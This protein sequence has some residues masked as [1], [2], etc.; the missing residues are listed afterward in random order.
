MKTRIA[1]IKQTCFACPSQ[2][3]GQTSDGRVVYV[4]YRWGG[5]SVSFGNSLRDAISGNDYLYA[6]A[7][8]GMDGL[9]T[10]EELKTHFTN[11][12]EWPETQ[13]VE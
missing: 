7:G 12:I 6:D 5:L 9:M 13:E 8:D 4:R 3:E 11:V 1:S 2:W 10:Y